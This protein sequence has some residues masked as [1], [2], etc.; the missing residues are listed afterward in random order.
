MG[1]EKV[2]KTALGKAISVIGV[3]VCAFLVLVL[4]V[5]VT[6]I[7]RSYIYPDK[8]PD[9]F[10][11]KP[12]IVLS[13]SMEPTILAGDLIVT[14]VVA[15][16][17]IVKD[18]IIAFRAAQNTVVTHRV[19]DVRTE[20]GLTFLTKGDANTGAD[21]KAVSVADLEGIYLWRAA[22]VGRFAMFLQT[23][24]GM[25]LFVITPLCLFIVYDITSRNRRNRKKADRE[26]Q[27]EAELAA[28]RAA[29]GGDK[30]IEL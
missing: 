27:L 10:G 14:K 2:P 28:L 11:Y 16:E 21:A 12:F 26:A 7:V 8:V 29:K 25:L 6:F 20:D 4:I 13:G 18:D 9:F 30:K 19:T 22:G 24:L 3:T 23:P 15:P 17:Q 5:N 1:E